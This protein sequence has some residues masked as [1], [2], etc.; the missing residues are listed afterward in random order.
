[1]TYDMVINK[2]IQ[3]S[4]QDITQQMAAAIEVF[5]KS[6]PSLLKGELAQ[7]LPVTQP[8]TPTASKPVTPVE[9]DNIPGP[10]S[11]VPL[12]EG[13]NFRPDLLNSD[14]DISSD[15]ESVRTSMGD[16]VMF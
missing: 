10:T 15:D 16:I 2:S 1:M 9:P 6:I 13:P 5:T 8:T 12:D 4:Q 11:G 14:T 7:F 3:K